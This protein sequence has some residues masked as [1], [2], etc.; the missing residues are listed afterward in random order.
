MNADSVHRHCNR[1][2]DAAFR[3]RAGI[4]AGVDF[5]FVLFLLFPAL[6]SL[7]YLIASAPLVLLYL[8]RSLTMSSF[9]YR[10][11]SLPV[12]ACGMYTTV[13]TRGTHLRRMANL[14]MHPALYTWYLLTLAVTL[15]AH[16]WAFLALFVMV[17]LGAFPVVAYAGFV[18]VV[19]ASYWYARGSHLRFY[20]RCVQLSVEETLDSAAT[21]RQYGACRAKELRE[22]WLYD[23]D[24]YF[25]GKST[26]ENIKT[27]P[28]KTP[29]GSRASRSRGTGTRGH[30]SRR[31]LAAASGRQN[32][33][34]GSKN[35]QKSHDK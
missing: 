28:A 34:N 7:F 6:A 20:E 12:N 31:S 11:R 18:A 2:I 22:R 32:N 10:H 3:R 9:L 26:I 29:R 30:D 5:V 15:P 17:A 13:P 8:V 35:R 4:F 1:L 19:F 25:H 16:A 23:I 21:L 33:R 27:L 24:L 14:S